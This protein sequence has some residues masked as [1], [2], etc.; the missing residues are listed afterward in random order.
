MQAKGTEAGRETVIYHW[1]VKVLAVAL[2]IGCIVWLGI[3]AFNKPLEHRH[4]VCFYGERGMRVKVI[5][6]AHVRHCK[7]GFHI[8]TMNGERL[9]VSGNV[10]V[11]PAGAS[12]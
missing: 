7:G 5:K 9:M 6:A 2:S 8:Q 3:E 11:R 10:I 1:L 12:R 4:D